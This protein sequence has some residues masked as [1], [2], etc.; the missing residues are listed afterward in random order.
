MRGASFKQVRR[1]RGVTIIVT[2]LLMT[3][4]IPLVGLAIDAGNLYAVRARIQAAADAASMAASRSLSAGMTLADQITK[5]KSRAKEYFDANFPEG[6]AGAKIDKI[7]VDV[8][9]TANHTRI[10]KVSISVDA[11][12]YFMRY[13]GWGAGPSGIRVTAAA[14]TTRR[15]VNLMLVLDRSGSLQTAGACDDLE[16]AAK[17]FVKL[18]SNKRDR[19]GLA[20]FGGSY[21]VDYPSTKNFKDSPSLVEEIDKLHPNGCLGWT[22]SAQG[23]WVGYQQLVANSEPGALNVIVFFTD[24]RPNTLTANWPV[25]TAVTPTSPTAAS[26]CYDWA[27]GVEAGKPGW[28]PVNQRYF[29]WVAAGSN[30]IRAP[31]Q[32]PMPITSET[33]TIDTPVGYTPPS[34]ISWD[35]DCFFLSGSGKAW[36]D[37]AYIPDTDVNGTSIFGWKSVTTF[38]PGHPYAGKAVPG[39]WDTGE[40][41]AINAVDNAA[42]RIRQRALDPA[43]D[44]VIHTIGLGDVGDDQHE[45]LRRIANDKTSSIFDSTSPEGRYVYSPTADGLNEAF[46]RIA[47][48]IMRFGK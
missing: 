30:G 24:G 34:P 23:L 12:A 44:V 11:P 47:A 29:G 21:R 28:N 31:V 9:E 3:I 1:R 32:A 40:N 39:N 46:A 42:A 33:D 36:R 15:D 5:C 45:L 18:F 48:E 19:M 2:A 13:L 14:E 8:T 37:I 17:S 7:N 20:T 35:D 26:Q 43:V 22:N 4:A 25:K 41:A 16:N 38:N 6:T 10:V 27:N